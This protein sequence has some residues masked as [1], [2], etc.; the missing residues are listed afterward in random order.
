[1]SLFIGVYLA[2]KCG[3]SYCSNIDVFE[4]RCCQRSHWDDCIIYQVHT[5]LSFL[6]SEKL[7]NTSG[8]NSAFI[9]GPLLLLVEVVVVN[10]YLTL[11]ML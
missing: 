10:S 5:V 3:N 4:Y 6:I 1:M 7:G 8:S 2:N 11:N 9:S